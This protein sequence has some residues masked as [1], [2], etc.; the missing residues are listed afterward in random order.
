MADR[1][2]RAAFRRRLSAIVFARILRFS[3]RA[4]LH[5]LIAETV[6]GAEQQ[7]FFVFQRLDAERRLARQAVLLRHGQGKGLVV[8]GAGHD[9]RFDKGLG[10]DD[11]VELAAAEQF[12]Q[13]VR[14]VF[15]QVE[16]HPRRTRMQRGDEARQQV[17]RDGVDRTQAKRADQRVAP[18][19]GQLLH[20]D[21]L[22]EHA[23]GLFGHLLA[24]R[25]QADF[26]RGALEEQGAVALL[27]F[28]ERHRERRLADVAFFGGAPEM[29]FA[30]Q[31][32][33]V[34]EFGQGH[35]GGVRR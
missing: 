9:A 22:F 18:L 3:R 17:R 14:V 31:G 10:D 33:N 6:A 34:A 26:G 12:G 23:L 5:H 24:D 13:A 30:R 32:H 4:G 11:H 19:L 20:L 7:Q 27:E 1:F 25:R 28:F 35:R 16:R 21:R 8:D 15:L 29:A 2:Q